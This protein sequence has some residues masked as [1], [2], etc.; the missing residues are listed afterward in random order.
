MPKFDAANVVEALDWDFT[1]FDG[2][3]GTTPE[4][5]EKILAEFLRGL[6]SVTSDIAK[7]RGDLPED[8]TPEQIIEQVEKLTTSDILAD[9]FSKMSE[10]YGKLCQDSPSAEQIQKLPMRHR[11]AF[12]RYMADEVRPEVFGA[13]MTPT[14]GTLRAV[15]GA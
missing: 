1:S 10:V 2:G 12:F 4:P 11:S 9:M 8:A 15:G 13:V 7:E 3:K 5:T 6:A 14:R